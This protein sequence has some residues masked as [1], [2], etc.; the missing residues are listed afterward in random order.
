MITFLCKEKNCSQ[1][2]IK[3]HFTGELEKAMCGGCKATLESFDLRDDP[4][5]LP[6]IFDVPQIKVTK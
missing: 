4:T 1:K 2:D 3:I 5:P 6:T